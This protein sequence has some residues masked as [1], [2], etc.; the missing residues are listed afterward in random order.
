MRKSLGRLVLVAGFL[1]IGLS[2][3][4]GTP[5]VVYLERTPGFKLQ[6]EQVLLVRELVRQSL[7]IAARDELRLLTRDYWLG[8]AMPAAG[9]SEPLD[10][11]AQPGKDD[12]IDIC[13]GAGSARRKVDQWEFKPAHRMQ[14]GELSQELERLSR[15]KFVE[16][17]GKAGFQGSPN[18]WK[19]E[20]PLPDEAQR[21][22]AEMTFSSQYLAVR[23][24]HAAV[25]SQGESPALLAALVRGYANLGVLTEFHWHPAHKVFKARA[26]LYAQRLTQR[27]VRP[28]W[29]TYH[30]AYAYAL[31]GLH[32]L[33][34]K[35]LEDAE[36]QFHAAPA[37]NVTERPTWAESLGAFCRYRMDQVDPGS[38]DAADKQLF[39]LLE[40]L[41]AETSGS[42]NV[43]VETAL[44]VLKTIPECYRVHDGLCRLAGVAAGH[45][46]TVSG[47]LLL[48]QKFYPRLENV[49][50]LSAGVQHAMQ[51]RDDAGGLFQNLFGPRPSD[52]HE[53]FKLRARVIAA[54]LAAGA[55][56]A[57]PPAQPEVAGEKTGKVAT[58]A[59]DVDRAEF[60]WSILGHLLRELSFAQVWQRAHFESHMLGVAPEKFLTLSEPLVRTHPYR[61]ALTALSLDF[62]ARQKALAQLVRLDPAS[63]EMTAE[64]MWDELWQYD[65]DRRNQWINEANR[66]MDDTVRDLDLELFVYFNV[67]P[68]FARTLLK[69][70]PHSPSARS[71]LI[72]QAWNRVEKQAPD[73]EKDNQPAVLAA[74]GQ[75]YAKDRRWADAERCLWAAIKRSPDKDTYLALAKVYEHQGNEEKYLSTLEG[76]LQQPDYGLY[77]A[78]VQDEITVHF[79]ERGQWE[80]ALPYAMA[81]ADTYSG[82]GMRLAGCCQEVLQDWGA[83][84]KYYKAISRR[85]EGSQFEWYLFCKRT[86]QGDL[87]AATELARGFAEQPHEKAAYGE[88]RRRISNFYLLERDLKKALAGY[89]ECAAALPDAYAGLRVVLLADELKD[90]KTR[91]AALERIK[92]QAA[93]PQRGRGKKPSADADLIGLAEL[94]A[95]DLAA[96][97][98][99]Q[100]DPAAVEKLCAAC[101]DFGSLRIDSFLGAYLDLHGRGD[102]AIR[103]WKRGMGVT[104]A[105]HTIK[106]DDFNRTL[107]GAN[108]LRHGV[109]PADYKDLV[110]KAPEAKKKVEKPNGDKDSKK[111]P[112]PGA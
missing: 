40:Y 73:W 84:E 46:A 94:I 83:A 15:T 8:E 80:K 60:S 49:A 17:L 104:T 92:A 20:L 63:I 87:P 79:A 67:R 27:R 35:E 36:K 106:L 102:E 26:L 16:L 55:A 7:L 91:D 32:A 30:R 3:A 11:I 22:L 52:P 38:V 72:R 75:H 54:L 64:G 37:G 23:R 71:V 101:G 86:G 28:L 34:I 41:D 111:A 89:S 48:D 21:L 97:G 10:L 13:R 62:E 33:A 5:G 59:A 96:G 82:W 51:V 68:R 2:A 14:Y 99:G 76:F 61:A 74:L 109:K 98:K 77:H 88:T 90:A 66:H 18:R 1:A 110:R 43:A 65:R 12:R 39:L 112:P 24:I 29:A 95:K 50:D 58:E 69:V 31:L 9:A 105:D 53:K 93:A 42:P 45:S 70:S 81:A 47:L 103:I 78:A 44:Q 4:A 107:C 56:E 6:N 57:P 19:P 108:L 25:R 85:Y 100:I